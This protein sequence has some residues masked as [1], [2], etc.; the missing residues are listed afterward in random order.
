M[1]AVSDT[2]PICYLILIGQ[3]DLLHELFD[4]L[5]VPRAVVAELLHEDAPQTVRAWAARLPSWISVRENPSG[6]SVALEKLQLGEWCAILL[7]EAIQA[8]IILLDEKSARRFAA[9]RGLRVTGT[10]GVLGEAAVRGLVDF[11]LAVK[12][13]RETNFRYS[14]AL[15][16]AAI[17]RYGQST[18]KS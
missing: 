12:R 8:D 4:Q 10:L 2:S 7:A 13:L 1:I 17:D 11:T 16:K 14:A 18:P 5:A 3:V 9:A 15:L 6:P